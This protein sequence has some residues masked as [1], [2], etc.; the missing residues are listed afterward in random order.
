MAAI[1]YSTMR[2][3]R[4]DCQ[5]LRSMNRARWLFTMMKALFL[6]SGSEGG[7]VTLP[8][9]KT[10]ERHLRCR[11]CVRLAHASAIPKPAIAPGFRD[12]LWV[13]LAHTLPP[14]IY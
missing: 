6:L 4:S 8:V 2:M 9:F 12:L 1:P 11:W 7:P 13:R 10:G 5:R 3:V 14:Y